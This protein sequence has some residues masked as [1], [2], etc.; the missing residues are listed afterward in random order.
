MEVHD[1]TWLRFAGMKV[2]RV[3]SS[4]SLA[5]WL[6]FLTTLIGGC[7]DAASDETKPTGSSE[8][9]AD[10]GGCVK[11]HPSEVK[12]WEGTNHDNAMMEASENSILG[13][14]ENSSFTEHGRTTRF[15]RL[16]EAFFVQTAD[17]AGVLRD[18]EVTHTFGIE[19]LQQYLVDVEGGR[20]QV[21]PF[22]WDVKRK[23]WFNADGPENTSNTDALH[24]T[25]PLHNWNMMCAECHAT[26]LK[27]GY[28]SRSNTFTT[29]AHRFD[30]GC[31]ACHGPMKDHADNPSKHST[32]RVQILETCAR[33]HSRRA[34]LSD[35]YDLKRGLHDDYH[36]SV[37]DDDLYFD[38]GQ[39]KGEVYEYGS[40][41]QSKMYLA[42]VICTDCH[43][44]HSTRL[45][46]DG[47]AMC[48]S[49]HNESGFSHQSINTSGL[50]KKNYNT[51]EHTGH[52]V[53]SKASECISCHAPTRTYMQIDPRHDHSFRVP[54]KSDEYLAAIRESRKLQQGSSHGLT[55]IASDAKQPAIRRATALERLLELGD[56]LTLDVAITCLSDSDPMVR[57]SA[58]NYLSG[59]SSYNK[60]EQR[61]QSTLRDPVRSVRFA[62]FNAMMPSLGQNMWQSVRAEYV[63]VQESIGGMGDGNANLGVLS[64]KEGDLVSAENYFRRALQENAH[65]P[66]VVINLA[67][68][69]RH[70]DESEAESILRSA[71]TTNPRSAELHYALAL[72]LIRQHRYSEASEHL[73]VATVLEPTNRMY[74][75]MFM[76][77]RNR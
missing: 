75:E 1:Y 34:P 72:S 30:V 65:S 29:T 22:A 55:F 28:D 17:G 49:C 73:R 24:W 40:F 39:I 38:D 25:K 46:A 48:T 12:A 44:P 71:S 59:F 43:D 36:V 67:D 52:D 23:K 26:G 41:V 3:W 7:K 60:V 62:A 14:F 18:F 77:S 15:Y 21:V 53:G 13:D 61:L 37:L 4:M 35:G 57:R 58:A 20:K 68:V 69:V 70:R 56:T 8:I 10:E 5:L 50:K 32:T 9:Y 31:Q 16:R 47:N 51:Q 19:P 66:T 76:L 45:R 63:T 74:N 2:L 11:C 33:C 6:C 64:Y 27:R 42:G 54:G